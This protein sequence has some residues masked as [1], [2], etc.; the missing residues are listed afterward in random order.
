M[1]S[2]LFSKMNFFDVLSENRKSFFAPRLQNDIKICKKIVAWD[3][4]KTY[5]FGR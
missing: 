2:N 5:G 3:V 1:V 4:N